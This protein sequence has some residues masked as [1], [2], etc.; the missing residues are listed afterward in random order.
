VLQAGKPFSSVCKVSRQASKVCVMCARDIMD[1]G[2]PHE[3]CVIVKLCQGGVWF[4]W[5]LGQSCPCR[6][7]SLGTLKGCGNSLRTD[8]NF[9]LL[10]T[11]PEV[12]WHLWNGSAF[13]IMVPVDVVSLGSCWV[14]KTLCL[15]WSGQWELQ[16]DAR[17]W[18]PL[19]FWCSHPSKVPKMAKHKWQ[20]YLVV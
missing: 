13:S 17:V 3:W 1:G 11:F 9:P 7:R 8:K 19:S 5:M 18:D 6:S 16:Y 10:V 20:N 2:V 15:Y 14:C 4:S 12:L